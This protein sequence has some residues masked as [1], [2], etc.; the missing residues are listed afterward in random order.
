MT[1]DRFIVEVRTIVAALCLY[2]ISPYESPHSGESSHLHGVLCQVAPSATI[3]DLKAAIAAQQGPDTFPTSRQ[4]LLFSGR[5]LADE[6]IVSDCGNAEDMRLV[7]QPAAP[8]PAEAARI[9]AE[10]KA[11]EV[12]RGVGVG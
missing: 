10:T 11:R 5:R 12:A 2:T 6:L 7:L 4:V 1:G 8:A 9:A 3:G